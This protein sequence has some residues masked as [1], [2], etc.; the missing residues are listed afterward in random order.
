MK[1]TT[2]KDYFWIIFGFLIVVS[3]LL[4][5]INYIEDPDSLRFALA[6]QEFDLVKSQPHFPAYPIYCFIGKLFYWA[7]QNISISLTLVGTVATFLI[8]YFANQLVKL[9][10]INISPIILLS[11]LFLNPLMWLMSTRFMPDLLGLAVVLGSWTYYVKYY[12]SSKK[13]DLIVFCFITALLPGIRLSYF[14]L[15]LFP[16]VYVIWTNPKTVFIQLGIYSCV[17]L[18]W[19]I[20]VIIDTGFD[21]LFAIAISHTNGHFNE[22]GGTIQSNNHFLLRLLKIVEYSFVDGMGMWAPGRHWSTIVISIIL[23]PLFFIGIAG[24]PKKYVF[25]LISLIV[26]LAWIFLYQNVVYK[27]RHILPFVPFIIICI[28]VGLEKVKSSSIKNM[29]YATALLTSGFIGIQLAIQHKKPTAVAQMIDFLDQSNSKKT[30]HTNPLIGFMIERQSNHKVVIDNVEPKTTHLYSI[31]NDISKKL[32][33]DVDTSY[34][35]YHNPY[36][37]RMWEH[38]ILIQYKEEE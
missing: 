6:I 16:V 13:R 12:Q 15:L 4:T 22:W 8:T 18:A 7:T 28:A 32:Q 9:L 31:Q 35:F 24:T 36:V 29:L 30:I 34:H 38:V 2:S 25:I 11:L 10:Y 14:P 1:N 21:N 5:R 19:L 17:T 20:P 23:L 27:S 3:R 37:N 26:Y 33:R